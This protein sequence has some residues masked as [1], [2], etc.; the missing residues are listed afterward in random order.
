LRE[1]REEF[2]ASKIVGESMKVFGSLLRIQFG[3][4]KSFEFEFPTNRSSS[5]GDSNSNETTRS[6]NL[7][8]L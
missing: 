8:R 4:L 7:A 5:N 3:L 2:H 6:E 1:Q